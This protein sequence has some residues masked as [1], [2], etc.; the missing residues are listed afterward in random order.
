MSD[1]V[2]LEQ[3]RRHCGSSECN[4]P[5][6]ERLGIAVREGLQDSFKGCRKPIR[7]SRHRA[8]L[9]GFDLFIAWCRHQGIW[10][11]RQKCGPAD[12]VSGIEAGSKPSVA[13][14]QWHLH[15]AVWKV[16]VSWHYRI[17]LRSAKVGLRKWKL[18]FCCRC[19]WVPS[20]LP[21]LVG[22]REGPGTYRQ[23][24]IRISPVKPGTGVIDEL[25]DGD[26]T[27]RALPSAEKLNLPMAKG[28]ASGTGEPY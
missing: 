10:A 23:R 13:V 18:R 5:T 4:N 25:V 1:R 12:V 9:R 21:R 7:R 14:I 17:A 22:V 20:V 2:T 3:T 26:L 8:G 11:S 24:Q 15:C 19:R 27:L 6:P 16:A 28:G